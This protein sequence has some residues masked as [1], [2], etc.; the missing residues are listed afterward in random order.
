MVL[1]EIKNLHANIEGKEILK[2]VNLALDSDKVYALMGPNGSGKSTLANVLMGHPNYEIT[3]GKILLNGEDI[4][5]LEADERAK[6]GMFLSFQYPKEISGVS[7][8]NFLRTAYNS[9]NSENKMSILEF[10]KRLQEKAKELNIDKEFLNRYLNEGFSGGEKKRAEILQMITLNPGFAILDETDSGLDIDA[11]KLVARGVNNFTG[12]KE[13]ENNESDKCVL[14][15]THY[16][17]ILD[18]IQPDKVFIMVGGKVV[19]EGE[20]DIVNH[21]EEKGYGWVQEEMEK[22]AE[23]SEIDEN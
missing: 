20:K 1:L 9:L 12:K 7:I 10:Q 5:E 18:Y 15:I 23:N 21:L 13:N 19:L 4:T 6:K 11:L 3:S 22:E 16:Q 17:R 2:G 14:I 8:S